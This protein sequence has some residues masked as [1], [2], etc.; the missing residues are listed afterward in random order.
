M[1][2]TPQQAPANLDTDGLRQHTENQ[3]RDVSRAWNNLENVTVTYSAQ[4]GKTAAQKTAACNNIGAMQ[5]IGNQTLTGGFAVVSFNNGTFSGTFTPNLANG[6]YQ[7]GT[8]NGA[9][10]IAN[11]TP[12]GALD[13]MVINGATAGAITFS[14][15]GVAAG[16]TGDP[17][18][19]ANGSRFI[20]SI[21]RIGSFSTYVIKALQ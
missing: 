17:L 14:G 6:N 20:I 12:D 15:Y 11:T 21:R 1:P 13:L 10:T 3:M 18:T 19:T 8:N 9:F 5:T 7:Y 16:N 2:F 4:T